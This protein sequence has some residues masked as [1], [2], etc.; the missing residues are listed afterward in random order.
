ML[1]LTGG[2]GLLGLHILDELRSRSLSVTALVRDAAGAGAVSERGAQ[3]VAGTVESP[4]TW[5]RLRDCSAIIHGAA[6][7]AG[8]YSWERFVQVNVSATRLAAERARQLGVPLIHISSVAVYGRNY[9]PGALVTESTPFAPLKATDRYARSKRMAEEVVWEEASRGLRAVAF[10]PCVVYGEGDRLFLPKLINSMRKSRWVPLIGGGER[11]LAL[12]HARNVAQAVVLSLDTP[13]SWGR[14]YNVTNDDTITAREF[15][16]AVGRGLEQKIRTVNIPAKPAVL[17]A[18][19]LD[20]TRRLLGPSRYPGSAL[21]AVRFWRGGNPYTSDKA[22]SELGW[23]PAIK[24]AQG[25][26][27]ATRA[28]HSPT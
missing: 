16:A 18:R 17:L 23:N 25:V 14:S 19:T 22:R 4:E 9:Q 2:S 3:P 8:R 10:R 28:L 20:F 6:I 27:D 7:I 21:S 26:E 13:A 11:P 15:V 5:A 24:H 1:F 12:V